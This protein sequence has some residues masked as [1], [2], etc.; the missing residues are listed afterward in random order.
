MEEVFDTIAAIN[1]RTERSEIRA[2]A[3][4]SRV[5]NYIHDT[6]KETRE[7]FREC[8]Y[9]FYFRNG[10]AGQAFTR[11][12]CKNCKAGCI[13]HNTAVPVLCLDCSFKY[14]ICVRCGA[15]L[16]FKKRE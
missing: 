14:N 6:T 10:I 13:Y 8:K 4:I 5:D 3:Y 15:D 12:N 1:E 2:N 9:C 16:D 7:H 11:F